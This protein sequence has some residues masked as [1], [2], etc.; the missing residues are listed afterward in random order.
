MTT[1]QLGGRTLRRGAGCLNCRQTG[2]LGR[3]GVFQLMP[4]SE[5]IRS[6]VAQQAASP[7]IVEAARREG[8][9]TLREAAVGKVLDGVTTVAE[10]VRVT[11]KQREPD[12]F[13]DPAHDSRPVN[14]LTLHH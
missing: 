4:I 3:D 8:M 13:A 6:L 2:Y 5:R 7:D 14:R 10:L 9:L 1:E 12:D 11:G